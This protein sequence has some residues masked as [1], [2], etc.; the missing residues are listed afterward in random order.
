PH[1]Q[2]LLSE[3][4]MLSSKYTKQRAPF[5]RLSSASHCVSVNPLTRCAVDDAFNPISRL[6]YEQFQYPPRW[7]KDPMTTELFQQ[8]STRRSGFR[9]FWAMGSATQDSDGN[10]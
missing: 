6:V 3:I 4:L 10:W 8:F 9:M 2:T 1:P 5:V 7:V